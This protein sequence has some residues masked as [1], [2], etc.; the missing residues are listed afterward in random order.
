MKGVRSA[1][2]MGKSSTPE[3][4]A[5]PQK[6]TGP[7]DTFSGPMSE[8]VKSRARQEAFNARMTQKF[9]D[10]ADDRAKAQLN[11]RGSPTPI[12]GVSPPTEWRKF[13]R[14]RHAKLI[15]ELPAGIT[16]TQVLTHPYSSPMPEPE[17]LKRSG[18]N[19]FS[20]PKCFLAEP[21]LA[22]V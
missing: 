14:A 3:T 11:Y 5:D 10:W 13:H 12:K 21:L 8:L 4:D 18:S 16:P 15:K 9:V 1:L 17:P 7:F 2:E 20:Q 6:Q 19:D 22:F